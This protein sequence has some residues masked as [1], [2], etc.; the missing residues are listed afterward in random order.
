MNEPWSESLQ[1]QTL[2]ALA[3]LPITPDGLLHM[4]HKSEGYGHLVLTELLA[5]KFNLYRKACEQPRIFADAQE[6]V[7]SGWAID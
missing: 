5:G 7:A 4:K 3:E 6:M 1:N 2:K